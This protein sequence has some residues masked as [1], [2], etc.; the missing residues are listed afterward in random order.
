MSCGLVRLI[1]EEPL[2]PPPDQAGKPLVLDLPAEEV[3]AEV[4]RLKAEGWH[5]ISQW[6]L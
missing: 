5:F 3:A 4:A 2:I 6:Q 1:C